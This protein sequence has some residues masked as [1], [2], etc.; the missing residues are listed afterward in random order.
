MDR[1][2]DISVGGNDQNALAV[3]FFAVGVDL[4]FL[5]AEAHAEDHAEN[6]CL[7]RIGDNLEAIVQRSKNGTPARL[8]AE[9]VRGYVD[10][11]AQG[12]KKSGRLQRGIVRVL[13]AAL[14]SATRVEQDRHDPAREW[15]LIGIHAA[16]V[17]TG[18]TPAKKPAED[19]RQPLRNLLTRA[20]LDAKTLNRLFRV[21]SGERMTERI[22]DLLTANSVSAMW[23]EP[24]D[25][26]KPQR[27]NGTPLTVVEY[28]VMRAARLYAYK[29]QSLSY[30]ELMGK[31][32]YDSAPHALSRLR[33][34]LATRRYISSSGSLIFIRDA[35]EPPQ[36]S[37]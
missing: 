12:L 28:A 32:G 8:A 19:A 34:N 4:W 2:Y 35:P 30:K 22:R 16:S 9:N 18:S 11:L 36:S 1:L 31:T 24:T 29:T 25:P 3:L 37:S 33:K 20:G 23:D 15:F 27:F 7:F 13:L 10:Q 6:A 21:G 17:D 5:M 14:R 26:T